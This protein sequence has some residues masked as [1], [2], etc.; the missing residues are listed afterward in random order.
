MNGTLQVMLQHMQVHLVE[1]QLVLNLMVEEVLVIMEEP[2]VS[3]NQELV[4]LHIFLV[5][6]EQL[7]LLVIVIEL[8]A[9]RNW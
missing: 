3:G 6:Q 7:R 8:P 4:V 5:I 2:Q 1:E 9:M